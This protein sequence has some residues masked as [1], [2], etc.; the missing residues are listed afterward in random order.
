MLIRVALSLLWHFKGN[1][2]SIYSTL[3]LLFEDRICK[4]SV[5]ELPEFLKTCLRENIHNIPEVF[6]N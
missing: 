4:Q 5:D 2:S 6:L 1:N 3:T